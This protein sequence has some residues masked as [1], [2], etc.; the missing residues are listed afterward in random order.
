M[1][2]YFLF[3][4]IFIFIFSCSKDEIASNDYAVAKLNSRSTSF[5]A[6]RKLI[7]YSRK[8]NETGEVTVI[9]DCTEP[10]N[11]CDVGEVPDSSNTH[12]HLVNEIPD[13]TRVGEVYKK[14]EFDT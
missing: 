3:L 7:T 10:G 6:T 1:K 13:S 5:V 2:R 8:D 12:V 4:S 14:A 11:T 9:Y